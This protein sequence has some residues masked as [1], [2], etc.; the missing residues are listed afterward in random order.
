MAEIQR[1]GNKTAYI[2]KKQSFFRFI[3]SFVLAGGIAALF[4]ILSRGPRLGFLYDF[5]LHLRPALPIAGEILLIDTAPAFPQSFPQSSALET[6]GNILEPSAA[7][8]IL[9][10]MSE[11][12]VSSLILQAPVLG[13]STGSSV[14][15]EE[16]RYRFDREYGILNRNIENLFDAI[17]MG[18]IS[19]GESARYVGEL[20]DLSERGKERLISAL[21]YQD[22]E[23]IRFLEQAMLVLGNV[24]HPGDLLVQVIRSGEGD[25]SGTLAGN[26]AIAE[27]SGSPALYSRARPDLDGVLRRIAPV[28]FAQS[29]EHIV[30]NA[31]KSRFKSSGVRETETGKVLF[32]EDNIES[33][34]IPLDLNGALLFEVPREDFKRLSLSVFLEYDEAD[35]S[36]RRLLAEKE[37]EGIYTLIQGEEN[38]IHLYDYALSLK[39]DLLNET[40]P[41]KRMRWKRARENYFTS[42]ENFLYGPSEMYLVNNLEAILS[43][44]DFDEEGGAIIRARGSLINTFSELRRKYK[45]VLELRTKLESSLAGSF[46]ILGP[47]SEIEASALLANSIITGRAINPGSELLLFPAFLSAALLTGL[48]LGSKGAMRSLCLGM[49][50]SLLTFLCFSISFL[51]SGIWLDPLIPAVAAGTVTLIH[52]IWALALKRHLSKLFRSCYGAS[53]SSSILGRLIQTGAPHPK[54][55]ITRSAAIVAIQNTDLIIYEK[56]ND[57]KLAAKAVLSYREKLVKAIKKAGGMAAGNGGPL[58][59]ACFGSPLEQLVSRTNAAARFGGRSPEERNVNEKQV[60]RALGLVSELLLSKANKALSIG[61]DFGPCS[62][63]WSPL[64]GY[65]VFGRPVA[66]ARRLAQEDQGPAKVLL[67]APAAK[68]LHE[69]PVKEK[70]VLKNLDGASGEPFYE[71]FL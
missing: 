46:C 38:P 23:G 56:E 40:L 45:E 18:L 41:E 37:A 16:I 52:F 57:P 21:L 11:F 62:F 15:E 12:E 67:S 8:S 5:L 50:L 55:L 54:E 34:S 35:Q 60:T 27:A 25:K 3:V 70:G 30:F 28:S 17:R 29:M 10:T 51:L 64:S 48:I 24:R 39:E 32:L 1:M 44:F 6:S 31:L 53:I 22:E 58:V 9:M 61:L 63:I 4:S 19:P 13:L 42:L 59:L 47:G 14:R 36:L 2:T 65:S 26:P 43:A 33:L 66:N 20:V 71:L 68:L 49:L 69:Y 7:A